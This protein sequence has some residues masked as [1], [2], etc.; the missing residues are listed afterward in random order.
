MLVLGID[1]SCDE[2]S[3]GIVRDGTEILANRISSQVALHRPFGGVVPEIASRS[4]LRRL[5]PVLDEAFLEAGIRP[6]DLDAVAAT[7][8]PGLIGALLVGLS[9]AKAL[10]WRLG[11]PFL[12]V[13]HI[14][15][16]LHAAPMTDPD[17]PFPCVSLI[18]S[19][20]HT[21]L[22]F[23]EKPGKGLRMGRTLDDAAGEALDK[24]A[25]LLGLGY[26]GGPALEEA[27]RLA[28]RSAGPPFPVPLKGRKD[29]DFSFSGLKTALRLRVEESRPLDPEETRRLAR[30]FQEAV[31]NHL[32]GRCLA[33]L[34]KT[35]ARALAIGGGVARN[36]LLRERLAR[37]AEGIHLSFPP[38]DLCS[39]NGAMVAG[40]ASLRL[41]RGEKDPLNLPA[42]PR[43]TFE[44]W[45]SGP[46][47]GQFPGPGR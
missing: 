13:D 30:A 5:L 20:G 24:A 46:E 28:D 44:T 2:T 19:G 16:H 11:I 40:L 8:K 41:E 45:P 17:L 27:A 29:F 33:A 22:F 3:V 35:G 36:R 39:D 42:A 31:V 6:R 34:Q 14:Q 4:H 12:G 23:M 43:T 10:A 32:A 21:S 18:A 9:G 15:A 1:T 7:C 37:E 26:P 25:A 47:P 38:P